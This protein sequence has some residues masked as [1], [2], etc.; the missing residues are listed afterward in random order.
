MADKLYDEQSIEA[1]VRANNLG[2]LTKKIFVILLKSDY[3][4]T[5]NIL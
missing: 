5:V 2:L 1:F 4:C 3:L